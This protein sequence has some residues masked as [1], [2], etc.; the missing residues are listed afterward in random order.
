MHD[1][2]RRD[3]STRSF[4][5]LVLVSLCAVCSPGLAAT[6]TEVIA[7]GDSLS[8]SGNVYALS[9]DWIPGSPYWQGRFSNGPTWVEILAGRLGLADPAARWGSLGEPTNYAVG[10][11][12]TDY[13][14]EPFI[15]VIGMDTQ[16]GWFQTDLVND[17][18]WNVS[19]ALFVVWGGGNDYMDYLDSG[20][21]LP[22]PAAN[23]R[24]RMET[25]IGLG[26]KTIVTSNLPPL[27]DI[28]K[29]R[30]T[31]KEAEADQLS[32]TFAVDLQQEVNELSALNAQCSF[33]YLDVYGVFQDIL[34]NPGDYGFSN[35]TD[36]AFDGA[37]VVPN[38][39]EYLFW[40]SEHPT[41]A[42]H[43]LVGN[44][45]YDHIVPEPGSAVLL[46]LGLQVLLSRRRKPAQSCALLRLT[47]G[48]QARNSKLP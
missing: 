35:V 31:A 36:P 41:R 40:D 8:D 7:F 24:Q 47:S 14:E 5:A 11:A 43:V 32:Q 45:A 2:M 21:P 1:K 26:A 29:Y 46:L 19:D 48:T 13:T 33:Y 30:N 20:G 22:T 38:P 10:G 34:A 42:G 25:L 4:A 23:L 9:H 12:K 16:V 39:D 28:P 17:P 18:S 37:N 15:G 27:G 44:N 3:V 6:Y